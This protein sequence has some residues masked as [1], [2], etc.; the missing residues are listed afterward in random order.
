MTWRQLPVG[1]ILLDD[2]ADQPIR[3]DDDL[4]HGFPA[5]VLL[6]F[7]RGEGESLEF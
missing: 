5:D 4:T 1:S 3:H 2:D 7:R 6:H